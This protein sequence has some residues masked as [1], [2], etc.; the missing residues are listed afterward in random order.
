[1]GEVVD[2][3]EFVVVVEFLIILGASALKAIH[4]CVWF[5]QRRPKRYIL[6]DSMHHFNGLFKDAQNGKIC[7]GQ[8]IFYVWIDCQVFSFY[9]S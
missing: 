2:I 4:P 7:V 3:D 1:M 6:C 8:C 9:V 5:I